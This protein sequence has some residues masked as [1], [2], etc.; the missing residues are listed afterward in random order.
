MGKRPGLRSHTKRN[1][2]SVGILGDWGLTRQMLKKGGA[3][4]EINLRRGGSDKETPL[5]VPDQEKGRV[6]LKEECNRVMSAMRQRWGKF[7]IK[8]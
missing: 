2:I 8:P 6:K 4:R 5:L 1:T 7:R 3:N